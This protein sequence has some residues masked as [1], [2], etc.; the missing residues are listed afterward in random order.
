MHKNFLV[1]I[2]HPHFVHFFRNVIDI[3]GRERVTITCQKSGIITDLL[4]SYG[5][6]YIIIGEKY[7]SL[8]AKAFGQ[9][10][11]L[12]KYINIIKRKEIDI[13]LG[14]S[15]AIAIASKLLEKKMFFFDDDDSAVQPLTKKLT[16]P[17]ADLIITPKCLEFEN[18]G[19]KHKTY[20][21]Y[22]ELAYLAPTYFTP[23][24]SIIDK[25]NLIA[26]A[27]FVVRFNEFHAH[28]DVGHEGIPD[29]SKMELIEHLKKY[30]DVYI[31]SEGILNKVY[32][33]YQL[34]VKP[35]DIHHVLA[36]AKMYIGDSQ[37]MASEAAVTGTPSFRC[38][39]FKGKIAYLK[40]LE[41]K[42]N[43]TYAYFP[44]EFDDMVKQIEELLL[45]EKLKD[46]WV[47]RKE[48]M[49]SDMVDV[50][51]YIVDLVTQKV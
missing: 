25:Y 10:K 33:K 35:E 3:I 13:L 22:Q 47:K 31:T 43:L 12:F 30:G 24:K 32:E 27:Y 15:P 4:D 6:S 16:N 46:I 51:R 5:Y 37:T 19:I 17:L 45:E 1:D 20:S 44:Y 18:Y 42:Y 36:F 11:Y 23:N 39:T 14:M 29:N 28:H 34:K 9:I 21:G 41:E 50:N 2:P 38:N 49:L 48:K 8:L 7:N 40:E 26:N